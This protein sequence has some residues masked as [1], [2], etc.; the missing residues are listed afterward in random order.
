MLNVKVYFKL[1]LKPK[2]YYF[3]KF[4]HIDYIDTN[5]L[6]NECVLIKYIPIS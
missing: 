1:T 5:M 6:L 3:I 4:I 2:G